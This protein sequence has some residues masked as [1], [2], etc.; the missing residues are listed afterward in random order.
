MTDIDIFHA[1]ANPTRRRLLAR[2]RSGSFSVNE[3]TASERVTQPAVS[4]HLSVLRAARLVQV[5]REGN[6]RIYSLDSRGLNALRRYVEAFWDDA[7]NAY[8]QAADQIVKE[9]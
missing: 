6:Q 2:L 3:L 4:Q 1:L 5:Q 9:E 7:L 8:Q